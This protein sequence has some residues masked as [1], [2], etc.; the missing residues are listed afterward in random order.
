[1]LT[2]SSVR[3]PRESKEVHPRH[4]DGVWW[5][6]E[7]EGPKRFDHFPPEGDQIDDDDMRARGDVDEDLGA[8]TKRWTVITRPEREAWRTCSACYL[9]SETCTFIGLSLYHHSWVA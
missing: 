9:D 8:Y 2:L 5:S 1:M 3:L 4:K 7:G 6:Q